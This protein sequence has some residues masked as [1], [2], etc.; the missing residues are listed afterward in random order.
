MRVIKAAKARRTN[1]NGE[2]KLAPELVLGG[3]LAVLDPLALVVAVLEADPV[4]VLLVLVAEGLEE[5]IVR[6]PE[7]VADGEADDPVEVVDPEAE[8]EGDGPPVI[9]KR[10]L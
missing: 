9:S 6:F 8:L 2:A 7:L 4:V 10:M 5:V 1:A 3:A